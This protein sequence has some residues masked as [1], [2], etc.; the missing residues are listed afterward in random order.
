MLEPMNNLKNF[1]AVAAAKDKRQLAGIT[2]L[3]LVG[4]IFGTSALVPVEAKVTET[5]YSAGRSSAIPPPVGGPAPVPG[6]G[7]FGGDFVTSFFTVELSEKIKSQKLSFKRIVF[8]T[9]DGKK[10][11]E[12]P[13]TSITRDF[14]PRDTQSPPGGQ[15]T[16]PPSPQT[17]TGKLFLWPLEGAT[18]RFAT[19]SQ[20]SLGLTGNEK[21][22]AEIKGR[23]G[24]MTFT[25]RAPV[26]PASG[27]P[28][29]DR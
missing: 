8:Y 20:K 26:G 7:G 17:V 2:V 21:I 18:L 12:V 9:E 19:F 5:H 10:V 15:N 14:K 11:G 23:S 3:L 13:I 24:L 4:L 6:P 22:Y 25:I 29:F 16:L 27:G 1:L 28:G